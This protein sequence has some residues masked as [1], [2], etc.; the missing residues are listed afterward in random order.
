MKELDFD[1]LD[2]AVNTLMGNVTSTVEPAKQ[3]DTRVLTITE[4]LTD[5]RPPVFPVG[6][7]TAPTQ[8]VTAPEPVAV[9]VSQ[10]ATQERPAPLAARRGG[11]FMDVVPPSSASRKPTPSQ[12][13]SRQGVSLTPLDTVSD[14]QE[15]PSSVKDESLNTPP[16]LTV[17][18]SDNAVIDR[19]TSE[20][21]DPLEFNQP[22]EADDT[23]AIDT[24]TSEE[25]DATEPLSSPF[26][27]DAKVE[28][29]PL[30]APMPELYSPQQPEEAAAS[31]EA[32]VTPEPTASESVDQP[33]EVELPEELRGDLMAI[34]SNISNEQAAVPQDS[35][36]A[37]VAQTT[38]PT[39]EPEM[40]KTVVASAAA[41]PAVSLPAGGGSIPQQYREEPSTSD[42]T[43]GSIYDTASYHQPLEHPAKKKT[44]WLWVIWVL[45]LL[46][47]GAGGGALAYLYLL[48]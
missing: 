44:G 17:E 35:P 2:R 38:R 10:S 3:D 29:R 26:L 48:Q 47:L 8:P 5:D 15:S 1:E 45:V 39:R 22:S 32:E 43:T 24:P 13:V 31:V 18:P 6:Q 23:P 12:G 20:W 37:P 19:D 42:Q 34:E 36:A 16:T 14:K 21:P 46:V 33:V 4:T 41:A 40:P 25:R 9:R 11:R 28:K 7:V 30:G 27:A